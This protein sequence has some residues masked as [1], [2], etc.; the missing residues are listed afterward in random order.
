MKTLF[1]CLVAVLF[2]EVTSLAQVSPITGSNEVLSGLGA[3]TPS[4]SFIDASTDTADFPDICKQ[5]NVTLAAFQS[6]TPAPATPAVTVDARGIY[7]T[8][9]NPLSCSIN[10]FNNISGLTGRLL[11]GGGV[12]PTKAQWVVPNRFWIEGIGLSGSGT[13][14]NTVIQASG[15]WCPSGAIS[16]TIYNGSSSTGCPVVYIG[17]NTQ[18]IFAAGIK[19]LTID[20]NS[21]TNCIGV[22]SGSVQE[23]SGID[24]VAFIN[25]E[26]ACIDFDSLLSTAGISNPFIRNAN[27]TFVASAA[28]ASAIGIQV[29]AGDGPAEISNVTV[30]VP[31][32]SSGYIIQDCLFLRAAIATD[33]NFLHC[34]HAEY[35]IQIGDSN[36]ASG[37]LPTV[38]VNIHGFT[39]ANLGNPSSHAG[40]GILI[41]NNTNSASLVPEYI[42]IEGVAMDPVP[43]AGETIDDQVNNILVTDQVVG[44]YDIGTSTGPLIS[45]SSNFPLILARV[46]HSAL[47]SAPLSS[48]PLGS[49]LYCKDCTSP[50]SPCSG[51]STGAFAV[52]QNSSSP[53]WVCK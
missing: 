53:A 8:T 39:S 38:G 3:A 30:S 36:L 46:T 44:Q 9:A 19:N 1:V 21:V 37:A 48:A 6:Q 13:L 26:L 28:V 27:C 10:P 29:Y 33:V 17:N 20:C 32:D 43:S 24:S 42:S 40:A 45:T 11:L 7:G 52:R 16:M 35:G 18:D 2:F 14:M 25:Q 51:S 15:T 5:I 41:E 49:V 12:I 47:T 31:N 34:E 22:G 23:G 50:S 4:E